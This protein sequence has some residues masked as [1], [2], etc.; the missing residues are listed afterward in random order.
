MASHLGSV[1]AGATADEHHPLQV[2][3]VSLRNRE[4]KQLDPAPLEIDPLAQGTGYRL[5]LLHNLYEHK[6]PMAAFVNQDFLWR[7]LAQLLVEGVASQVQVLDLFPGDYCH[8]ARFQEPDI[9]RKGVLPQQGQHSGEV[10]A[11]DAL[12]ISMGH[13]NSAS[14]P[15]TQ[16]ADFILL[17]L[18]DGG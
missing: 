17:A 2:A 5:G 14:V 12:S 4:V 9:A 7:N 18:L 6:V 10:A 8:L 16:G 11:N 15:Q 3:K 13:H 1:Q